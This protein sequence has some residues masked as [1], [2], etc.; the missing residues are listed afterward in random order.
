M[1]SL[2][3]HV[4]IMPRNEFQ[5]QGNSATHL[6]AGFHGSGNFGGAL[7]VSSGARA[8]LFFGVLFTGVSNS[9]ADRPKWNSSRARLSRACGASPGQRALLVRTYFILVV[10]KRPL[11]AGRGDCGNGC[12]SAAGVECTSARH[13]GR[14]PVCI[15]IVHRGG[16]GFCQLPVRRNAAGGWIHQPLLGALGMA[17]AMGRFKSPF[18]RQPLPAPLADV[19]HLL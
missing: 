18:P 11:P 16:A 17:A 5:Y 9:R 4:C 12:V 14:L 6:W 3:R 13:A 10:G 8:Y 19:P 2:D 15:L 7:A 1:P